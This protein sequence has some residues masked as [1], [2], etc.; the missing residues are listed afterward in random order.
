MLEAGGAFDLFL[1]PADVPFILD[2]SLRLVE[3]M[4]GNFRKRGI[5]REQQLDRN[6]WPTEKLCIRDALPQWLK[7]ESLEICIEVLGRVQPMAREICLSL[8]EHCLL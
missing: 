6:L 8:L 4:D 7:T 3:H 2:G 1:L 5:D